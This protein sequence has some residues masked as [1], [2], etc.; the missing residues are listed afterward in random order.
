MAD[1][2][3]VV[4]TARVART[5]L[6]TS[7]NSVLKTTGAEWASVAKEVLKHAALSVIAKF[8]GEFGEQFVGMLLKLDRSDAVLKRLISSLVEAPLRTGMDQLELAQKLPDLD[9][10][11][12]NY[13]EERF[14][15]ALT[16]L[17]QALSLAK[18][19]ERPLVEFLRGVAA[20]NIRGGEPEA[21]AHFLEYKN[22]CRQE[23]AAAEA[24]AAHEHALAEESDRSLSRMPSSPPAAEAHLDDGALACIAPVKRWRA[25]A[26]GTCLWLSRR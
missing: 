14:R 24:M 18:D 26:L 3:L 25:S 7:A 16:S 21:V 11:H 8:L 19:A 2:D 10:T 9:P 1:D 22:A 17:D 20:L 13:R 23:R 6:S 4:V 5:A 15:N 12:R